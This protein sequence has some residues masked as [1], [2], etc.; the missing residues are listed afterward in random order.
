MKVTIYVRVSAR[1]FPKPSYQGATKVL[2]QYP[3]NPQ[4]GYV[5]Q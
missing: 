4:A 2:T 5:A 1:D 3:T